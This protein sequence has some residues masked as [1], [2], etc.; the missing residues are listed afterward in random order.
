[1]AGGYPPGAHPPAESWWRRLLAARWLLLVVGS[2][3][4]LVLFG[5]LGD[6]ILEPGANVV[7]RVARSWVLLHQSSPALAAAHILTDVGSPGGTVAL[8][9]AVSVWLWVRRRRR[10]AAMVVS[11]PIAAT[12]G[13]AGLKSLFGRAR[14]AGALAAHLTTY[15]FPS[16]HATVGTAVWLTTAYCLRREGM[17]PRWLAAALGVGWPIVI[18][19]TRVYLDVHWATDVIGGWCLGAAVAALAGSMY[20]RTRPTEQVLQR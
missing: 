2:T 11:A 14:P 19:L 9:V 17:I 5:V 18:G 8:G 4:A 7:D 20:E 12:G 1:M 13:F 10:V 16:G 3:A 6:E 15:S